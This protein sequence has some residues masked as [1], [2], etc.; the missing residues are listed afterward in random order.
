MTYPLLDDIGWA[1][2]D[3]L[4]HGRPQTASPFVFVRHG[5]PFEQFGKHANLHHIITTYTRRAGIPV[6][7][8]PHGMHSLRHTLASALL[9]QHTPLPVIADILGH[10]STQSTQVYLHVDLGAL[11][12]CALDPE[13]VFACVDRT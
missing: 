10:L 6:P 12:R 3:Y 8:G 5:A 4:Q 13:E 2:I 7:R 11:R 1:L 9:E